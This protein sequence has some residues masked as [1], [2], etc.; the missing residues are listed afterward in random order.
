MPNKNKNLHLQHQNKPHSDQVKQKRK[1]RFAPS[2]RGTTKLE[3][4][5]GPAGKFRVTV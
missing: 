2:G 1:K 4:T 5:P 3:A